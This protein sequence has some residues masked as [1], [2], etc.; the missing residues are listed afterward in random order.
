MKRHTLT[1]TL[2]R[3]AIVCGAA[4]LVATSS[5]RAAA[6]G[7]LVIGQVAPLTGSNASNGKPVSDGIKLY[8]DYVNSNGGVNGRRIKF[9]VRDDGYKVPETVRHARDLITK[10][11]VLALMTTLGTANNEALL[12][13]KLSGGDIPMLG[14]RSGASSL[15]S[16][17]GMFP[18]RASYHDEARAIIRQLT[19]TG[20]T[21]IATVYQDDSFGADALRGVEN[22]LR[23]NKL[24]LAAKAGFE[25]N[26]VKIEPAVEQMLK[27]NPQ[28]IV[29]LAVTDPTAAFVREFRARGGSSQIIC[30]SIVDPAAVIRHAGVDAA[31]GLAM[32]VV[33]PAPN[34]G[35]LPIIKEMQRARAKV[36]AADFTLTLNS[37]EGFIYGKVMT[38]A[39]RRSGPTPTRATVLRALQQM[40][41]YDVGGYVAKLKPSLAEHRYV[42]LAVIG[43]GGALLQ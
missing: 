4:A 17:P 20:L 25:R 29:M 43:A 13:E 18:I 14:P 36:G 30:L 16:V 10:E 31:R 5:V 23:D 41:S 1:R 32:T 19:T 12:K 3:L 21:R 37:I 33:V 8:F 35:T 34:Q 6:T 27:A 24:E 42:D 39:L 9:I 28:A 2:I 40:E 38:E 15:Y 7:E 22:A 26:T 11:Q